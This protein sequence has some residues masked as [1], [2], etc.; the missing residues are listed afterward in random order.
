MLGLKFRRQH[1][2]SGFIVDFYCAELRLVL[3][4]DGPQHAQRSPIEYDGARTAFLEARGYT[5]IRL[6]NRDLTRERLIRTL[7]PLLPA[8]AFPLSR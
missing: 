6:R 2:I 5:V 4:L 3:E 8:G 7:Q 1:V